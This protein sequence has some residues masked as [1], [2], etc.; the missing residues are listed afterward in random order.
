MII[1]SLILLGFI[2][3]LAVL[4]HFKIKPIAS[5]KNFSSNS[6]ARDSSG[7]PVSNRQPP[8]LAS[9]ST[10][11][12]LHDPPSIRKLNEANPKSVASLITHWVESE[13]PPETKKQ[14]PPYQ[15]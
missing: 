11:T 7:H 6:P 4:F 2:A 10:D 1:E 5:P 12:G 9:G 15:R 8:P 14:A 13:Q 3:L